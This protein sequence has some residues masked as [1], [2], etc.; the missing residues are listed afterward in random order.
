MDGGV[1]FSLHFIDDFLTMGRA[2]TGQCAR[3]LN[4]VKSTSKKNGT[5][6]KQVKIVGP[7]TCLDFLGI[8]LDTER[9]QMRLSEEKIVGLKKVLNQWE[10]RR[11]CK[12]REL[13]SLIGKLSH[14]CKIVRPGRIFLR[15]MIETSCK[16][17]QLDHWIRLTEEFRAD[18][19]W[20]ESFLRVW[21]G[22][23]LLDGKWLRAQ[24]D[25][26][27]ASDASGSWGYGAVWGEQWVQGQ[28]E[29]SWGKVNIATKE[30]LPIVI[31][32]AVWG[33]QWC[34]KLVLNQCDNMAVVDIMKAQRSKDPT[35]MH[36]LRCLHFICA[37]WEIE[38]RVEHIPGKMNVVADAVSRNLLQVMESADLERNPVQVPGELWR[39]LVVERPDWLQPTWRSLLTASLT[40]VS[41]QARKEHMQ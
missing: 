7:T 24:P 37:Y 13:L 2:K 21:N 9:F 17:S 16:C 34:C 5:P 29:E 15:R 10:K 6:L 30:L 23:S 32:C 33:P 22:R 1:S 20:W 25:V 27:F 28:W 39:L 38:L 19:A 3:N 31:S 26:V 40:R 8:E 36:L 4:I 11:A 12:K 41:H 35:I 14:A 18:L